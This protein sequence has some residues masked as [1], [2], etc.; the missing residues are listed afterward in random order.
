MIDVEKKLN[1]KMMF[2]INPVAGKRAIEKNLAEVL[3][4]FTKGGYKVTVFPTMAKEDA[5]HYV[6][7]YGADYDIICCSGGDGTLNE[8]ITGVIDS[9]LK[10]KIGYIPCGSTNDFAEYHGLSMDA[11]EAAKNIVDGEIKAI[12]IGAIGDRYFINS[13]EFGV[14]TWQ[15]YTTSQT[16]KNRLG[17]KAY[18]LGML[19]DLNKVCSFHMKVE[20]DGEQFE[21]DFIFGVTASSCN[22]AEKLLKSFRQT[23]IADDGL[24][25][26]ALVMKPNSTPDIKKLYKALKNGDPN[27]KFIKFCRCTGMTISTDKPIDWNVDG[28]LKTLEG[29]FKIEILKRRINLMC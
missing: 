13:A 24:F 20:M 27:M 2:I 15:A 18:F 4:V 12:D 28:E 21:D 1:K 5:T 9:G 10:T 14:F 7:E 29:T 22:I 25:E 8:V 19:K 6:K 26:I 3:S 23:V 16:L 11:V 17:G